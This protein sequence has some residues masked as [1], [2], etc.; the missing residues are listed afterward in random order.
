LGSPALRGPL[1]AP[2]ATT[3]GDGVF[4]FPSVAAG[5]YRVSAVVTRDGVKLWAF[6][7]AEVKDRDLEDV[8]LRLTAPFSIPGKVVME[9]AEG[10]P[11]PKFP[12]VALEYGDLSNSFMDAPPGSIPAGTPNE[13][14]DVTF[15]NVYPGPYLIDPS[16]ASPPYYL[17]SIRIGAVNALAPDV[18]ISLGA[19][20]ITVTYKLNGGTVRGAIDSCKDG[21]VLLIPQDPAYRRDGFIY[22]THCGESGL[23]EIPAV[24]PGEYYGLAVANGNPIGLHGEIG[25]NLINQSARVSVRANEATN[26][27]IRLV[28]R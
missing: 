1:T 17:D 4:E 25:Q 20:L 19:G 26:A 5:E 11:A 3:S 21:S 22:R 9:T 8:K 28:K 10:Q 23:F 15:L 16:S 2:Q 13:K 12:R 24:R 7:P 18:P 14:G 27:E 6:E